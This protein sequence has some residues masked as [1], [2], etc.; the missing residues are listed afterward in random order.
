MIEVTYRINLIFVIFQTVI[1]IFVSNKENKIFSNS[2]NISKLLKNLLE[3]TCSL[4][5]LKFCAILEVP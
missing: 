3:N 4:I 5:K 2:K 1:F